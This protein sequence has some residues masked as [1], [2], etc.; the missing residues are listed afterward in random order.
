MHP[1]TPRTQGPW[2]RFSETAGLGE[3]P[4]LDVTGEASGEGFEVGDE[5]WGM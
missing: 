4:W 5:G 2:Q 1:A 3:A